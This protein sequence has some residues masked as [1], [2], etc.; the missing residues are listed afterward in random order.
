[1]SAIVARYGAL[2]QDLAVVIATELTSLRPAPATS[3]TRAR[4]SGFTL[5]GLFGHAR[6]ETPTPEA[7]PD[8]ES[9]FIAASEAA[10]R[11]PDALREAA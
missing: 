5:R 11:G 10:S 3:A 9:A 8:D 2:R 4:S 7:G 1:M 6:R